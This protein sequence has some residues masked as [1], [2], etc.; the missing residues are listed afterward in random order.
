LNLILSKQK[1]KVV[2]INERGKRQTRWLGIDNYR[3][4]NL[5]R[6]R[7]RTSTLGNFF[8]KFKKKQTKNPERL[9]KDVIGVDIINSKRFHIKVIDYDGRVVNKIYEAADP[10]IGKIVK[11]KI[12]YIKFHAYSLFF[13]F[14]RSRLKKVKKSKT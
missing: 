13:E 9:M 6:R 11:A 3:I 2:K 10:D 14:S 7:R 12:D 4:Y 5:V 1:F 8:E